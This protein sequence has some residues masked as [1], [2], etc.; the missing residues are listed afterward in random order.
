MRGAA[1]LFKSLKPGFLSKLEYFNHELISKAE[2][3]DF[4]SRFPAALL[5]ALFLISLFR[6]TFIYTVY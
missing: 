4:D 6:N 1:T 3:V 5:V 2:S